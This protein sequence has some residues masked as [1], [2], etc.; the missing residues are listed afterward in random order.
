MILVLYIIFIIYLDNVYSDT[1]VVFWFKR[2]SVQHQKDDR[3]FNVSM[4]LKLMLEKRS[5][6]SVVDLIDAY[7]EP[8]EGEKASSPSVVR[9][10]RR[11]RSKYVLA[12]NI[13]PS[14]LSLR[15]ICVSV[16]CQPGKWFCVGK[17]RWMTDSDQFLI[18]SDYPV[19]RVL[20]L[21]VDLV[22]LVVDSFLPLPTLQV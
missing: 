10:G 22:P 6:R 5:N 13:N 1:S 3:K 4:L 20:N 17:N 18:S 9:V 19:R 8:S 21:T 2:G 11:I 7:I 16:S 15:S 12:I 14:M